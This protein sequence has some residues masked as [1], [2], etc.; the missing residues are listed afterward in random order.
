MNKMEYIKLKEICDIIWYEHNWRYLDI[1]YKWEKFS[2]IYKNINTPIEII[3]TTD[4]IN[5]FFRYYKQSEKYAY[6]GILKWIKLDL[7]ENLDD[8]ITF[9]YNIIHKQ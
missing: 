1:E 8:P 5:D 3:F 2:T 6:V 7:L 4:F 9:L